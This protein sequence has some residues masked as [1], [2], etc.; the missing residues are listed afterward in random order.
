MF[1]MPFTATVLPLR[2]FA[3]LSGESIGTI[4]DEIGDF[5]R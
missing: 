2:S 4:S 1:L 5:E 3:V